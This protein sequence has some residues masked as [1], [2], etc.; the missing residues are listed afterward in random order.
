M[1][2]AYPD[3][4]GRKMNVYSDGTM[5]LQSSVSSGTPR[6]ASGVMSDISNSA[7]LLTLLDHNN[8]SDFEAPN[9]GEDYPLVYIF[10]E[11][12]DIDGTF[13]SG[14][15]TSGG[16][17]LGTST[18]TTN[19]LDGSWTTQTTTRTVFAP[20]VFVIPGYR[21]DVYEW[22]AS[23]VRAL[24][25]VAEDQSANAFG[26]RAAEIFGE[27]AS[28]ETPDR[29]ILLDDDTGLE[30]SIPQDWGDRPRGTARDKLLRLKNNSGSL[31]ASTIDVGRGRTETITTDASSWI[32]LDNGAGFGSTF[33]VS[34]LTSGSTD[35]FTVRQVIPDAAIPGLYETW[36]DIT[37]ASW[38]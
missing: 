35:T 28:G 7:T 33:Q 22:T 20:N 37:V 16:Y 29:I 27:I 18:D 12:R 11:L 3:A 15:S 6:K 24:Q 17:Y 5:V 34:S 19:G 9:G 21:D 1:S 4:P 2:G 31:T 30:V 8:V 36:I 13:F 10:P 14:Y 25:W 23:A 32:E 26:I 38:A